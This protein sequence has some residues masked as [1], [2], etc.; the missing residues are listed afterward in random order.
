MPCL[1]LTQGSF[2]QPGFGPTERACLSQ[3]PCK[4]LA[5]GK[6]GLRASWAGEATRTGCVLGGRRAC[7]IRPKLQ[8]LGAPPCLK[9]VVVAGMVPVT[10]WT[11]Q[12]VISVTRPLAPQGRCCAIIIP[13]A[14]GGQVACPQP[15]LVE[16]QSW[17]LT[18]IGLPGA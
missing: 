2:D 1:R 6:R 9:A 14:Q 13:K 15:R 4:G 7:T 5:P 17:G 8:K 3:Q 18:P 11:L 10:E 12:C 16:G